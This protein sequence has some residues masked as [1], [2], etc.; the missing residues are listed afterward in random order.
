MGFDIN[1]AH[2]LNVRVAISMAVFYYEVHSALEFAMKIAV[3]ALFLANEGLLA[4]KL[5]LK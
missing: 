1:P 2:H 4:F 3:E 5:M